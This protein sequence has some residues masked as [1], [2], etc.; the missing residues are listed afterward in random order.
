MIENGAGV[1][2]ELSYDT[3]GRPKIKLVCPQKA[4]ELVGKTKGM[5]REVQEHSGEVH[6]VTINR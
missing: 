2:K 3:K 5:F 4:A 1:V 6:H